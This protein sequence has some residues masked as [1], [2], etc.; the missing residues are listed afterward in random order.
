M[1][2]PTVEPTA[3]PVATAPPA[4]EAR[5][6]SFYDQLR[7]RVESTVARRGGRWGPQV[8]SALLLV[9]DVFFLLARLTLDRS[10]PKE[11]RRLLGGALAYFLLPLDLLPELVVGAGGY[12]E[13][14]V[15]ASVVLAQALGP[16]LETHAA[17]HWSGR[18][19]VREALTAVA[20]SAE[21]L[22]GE[23]LY[24]RLKRLLARRGFQ[25]DDSERAR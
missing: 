7:A 3:L 10:V 9:P 6:L 12:L 8:A 25:L 1:N 20:R 13:D 4:S 21:S 15:L 2:D 11:T 24:A 23:G 16:E 5:L 19:E 14:L 17:R 22:L 18:G